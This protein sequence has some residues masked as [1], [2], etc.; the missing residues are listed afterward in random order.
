MGQ[1]IAKHTSDA[2]IFNV[3]FKNFPVLQGN[4]HRHILKLFYRGTHPMLDQEKSFSRGA[5]RRRRSLSLGNPQ[6]LLQ[7]S[8]K[9]PGQLPPKVS[10]EPCICMNCRINIINIKS[11]IY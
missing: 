9:L 11:Y 3:Y 6:F 4:D 8:S 5:S 2:T 7:L 1:I 10:I